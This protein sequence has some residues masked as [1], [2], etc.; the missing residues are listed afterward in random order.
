[1]SNQTTQGAIMHRLLRRKEVEQ[2]LGIS[3]SS[4]YARLDA[5][6]PQYDPSFPKPI[7]LSQ[8]CVAWVSWEVQRW[9]NERIAERGGVQ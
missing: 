1:M 5:N 3:R 4:I 2:T 9:I 7:K 6:S 8:Q